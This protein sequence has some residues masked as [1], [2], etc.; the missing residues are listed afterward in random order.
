M[1]PGELQA[2]LAPPEYAQAA[3]GSGDFMKKGF[4][5]QFFFAMGRKSSPRK[6]EEE[7]R[8]K[9]EMRRRK[10]RRR[11]RKKKYTKRILNGKP[12]W[13]KGVMIE[14]QDR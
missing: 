1:N 7:V 2:P 3:T 4:F 6:G 12:S 11:R 5:F 10:R 13:G 14:R 8:V 9:K